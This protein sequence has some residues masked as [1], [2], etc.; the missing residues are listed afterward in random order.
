M[1]NPID[2]A[3]LPEKILEAIE[4]AKAEYGWANVGIRIQE[5]IP[6]TLGPIDHVSNVWADGEDTGEE[7]PG[8]CTLSAENMQQLCKYAACYFGNHVAILAGDIAGCGEDPGELILANA[9]VVEV[10]A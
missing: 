9:E 2:W 7:L 5:D 4:A 1:L 6:F 10:L 3:N 8:I